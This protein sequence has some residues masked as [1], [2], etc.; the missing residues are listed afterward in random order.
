MVPVNPQIPDFSDPVEPPHGTAAP[1]SNPAARRLNLLLTYASWQPDS[2]ADRIPCLLEPMGV[3]SIRARS[4]REAESVIRTYPV[5]IAVVDLGLPMEFHTGPAANEPNP[6][7][8]E[9]AGPRI[10][11]LL[12]RLHTVP[13]TVIVK[14]P[15][16]QRDDSRH[17]AAALRSGAFAVVDRTSADLE[18]ML[19]I[20]R[21]CLHRFYKDRWPSG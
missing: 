3:H 16:P 10:L 4:A 2:W 5:H 21:R 8:S 15:R 9:E 6:V 18:Q 17:L 7:S 19:E 20:L 11:D 12:R 1:S 13:P 14:P